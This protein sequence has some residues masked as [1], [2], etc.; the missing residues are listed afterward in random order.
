MLLSVDRDSA[1]PLW[2]QICARVA[3]L[4]DDGSL[5]PGSRL[6]PSRS[7]A[8]KVGVNRSTVYRAYQELWAQ[9]YLDSRPGSYS[10]VRGR[11]RPPAAS[12]DARSLIDW[13]QVSTPGAARA[14]QALEPGPRRSAP[15]DGLLD[16]ASLAADPALSP[17][18][19]LRRAL[20]QVLANGGRR[21]MDYGDPAGYPPLR[22]TIARRMRTHG[23]KVAA[24][25]ILITNGAQ[26]AIDLVLRLVLHPKADLALESPTY[27]A[28]IPLFKLHG[29]R[30][31]PLPMG[32]EGADL[33][34]LRTLLVRRPP[35]LVYSVPNFHNPT[36]ITTGQVHRERLLSL[37]EDHRV[38]LLED[39]FEEEMKYFGKAVLPIKSMD[40]G[41]VVIYVGTFSK[42]VFSGL[43][44]GWIAADRDCIRR[45]CAISRYTHLSG[46][47]LTQA[48]LQCFCESGGYEWHLRRLHRIY[49]RRMQ[50]L[51]D[52]LDAH[53]PR[54]LVHWTRP[55]GGYTLWL[56]LKHWTADQEAGIVERLKQHDVAVSAGRDYFPV[57]PDGAYIRISIAKVDEPAIESGCRKLAQVLKR[58]AEV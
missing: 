51:L 57:S 34:A 49:R 14:H 48:A 30:L 3:Q 21:L 41:G 37:C 16:F 28:A 13:S 35:A 36:G 15:P 42:V 54:R 4:V 40:T 23:V 53:L 46:N 55:A 25:Q 5:R 58:A 1:V 6:P 24:D 2:K 12:E 47:T 39:G 19:E 18:D 20:R 7:L 52:G 27:A 32:P 8:D 10:V 31:Q 22:E 56:H 17:V 11:L 50:T 29:A 45:L 9:G 26:H 38:P 44:V 33:D 43:R